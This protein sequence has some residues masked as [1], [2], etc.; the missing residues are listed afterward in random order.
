MQVAGQEG[1]KLHA[2]P[3]PIES[4]V[5]STKSQTAVPVPAPAPVVNTSQ[6]N[7]QKNAILCLQ[8]L[9]VVSPLSCVFLFALGMCG[10]DFFNSR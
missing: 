7:K 2:A 8:G 5:V 4:P 6:V 10:S 9:N 3:K 1:A